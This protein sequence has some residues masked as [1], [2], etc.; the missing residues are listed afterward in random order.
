M[1]PGVNEF[2]DWLKDFSSSPWFYLIIF[3]VALLD[4]ILPIVPSETLVIIGGVAAGGS[5]VEGSLNVAL[6]IACGAAGAFCGD[7]LS[8]EIGSRASGAAMRRFARTASGRAR[9]DKVVEQIHERGGL[10]LVT[11]RFIP[12]GRTI[13]TLACGITG[14]PRAW[15]ARWASI[16]AAIWAT[17]AAMLGYLGGRTFQDNHTLAFG[18]AFGTAVSVTVVIEAV[19]WALKRRAG[20]AA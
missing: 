2:F 10:L 4:S 11:A 3:T 19:R 13:L 16:A 18:V 17:Y 12:G 9:Y 5:A 15:F 6:V 1:P 8:Y 14:Q 7:N 20:D